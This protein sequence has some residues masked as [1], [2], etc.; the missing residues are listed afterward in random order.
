MTIR[1]TTAVIGG[2][3][4]GADIAVTI[5]RAGSPVHV[6]EPSRST[7]G[8]LAERVF[9]TLR[10]LGAE[11]HVERL[12]VHGALD[13]VPWKE[14]D[15]V[16]EAIPEH[17]P[18]KRALF[19]EL[20]RL[21]RADAWLASNSSAIPISEIGAG[22]EGRH[23]MFGLHYFMP[24][25]SVPLVELVLS[26]E[27]DRA[28]A[29]ELAAF[30]RA[31][32]KRPVIVQ[33]DIP[34]FIGNRLQHALCREAFALLDAGVA[35]AEDIDAAVRFSFG[36]R[37]LAVGPILQR[38]HAGL[39]VHMAAAAKMYPDLADNKEPAKVLRDHVAA[40]HLGI[41]AGR[42]FFEWTPESI[43]AEKARYDRLLRGA[44]ALIADE[45]PR[46]AED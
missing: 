46:I 44:L 24:A 26:A 16:I 31:T 19:A 5:A 6:V 33:K 35:S 18:P 34:G 3:T 30:M 21:A 23:R 45:V 2:G 36:F 38:D 11:R 14:V 41:K 9:G 42:G 43:A 1:K 4:M 7:R 39:D 13:T 32:G 22:L 37:Y 17:L 29:A 40:G 8:T 28:L 20:V 12:S 15:L 25:H 10:D 27:S